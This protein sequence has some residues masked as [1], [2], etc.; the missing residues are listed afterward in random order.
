M[1]SAGNMIDPHV[2]ATPAIAPARQQIAAAVRVLVPFLGLILA[3]I[4]LWGRG[5][6]G[7]D[8]M[9][10]LGMYITTGFGV[11]IG[12]H[13]LFTHRS[14]QA[15]LLKWVAMH[16]CHHEHSDRTEDPHS[17]HHDGGGVRGGL[18]GFWNA[19]VGWIFL[20]DPP[21]LE[22]DVRDLHSDRMLR[23][24]SRLFGVRVFLGLL[25]PAVLGGVFT[26]T[27]T[28]AVMGSSGAVSFAS[29]SGIVSRGVSTRSAI[30]G[31]ADPTTITRFRRRPALDCDG[32]NWI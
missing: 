1:S 4:G 22:R 19:H 30:S 3:V 8:L 6:S 2:R 28:G 9:L 17:P 16:R 5:V 20:A 7:V 11:T 15:A 24:T 25:I 29:S 14:F 31:E 21:N 27:W 13:R 26:G 32:G 18:A 10:L 12:F 23:F